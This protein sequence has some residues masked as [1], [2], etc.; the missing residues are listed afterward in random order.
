MKT[1]ICDRLFY[2][3]GSCVQK[4]IPR[5]EVGAQG[6]KLRYCQITLMIGTVTG[7]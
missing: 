4:I 7:E 1:Y 5:E 3:V 6:K 2:T